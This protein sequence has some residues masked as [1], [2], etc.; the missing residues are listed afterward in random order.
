MIEA[1]RSA[2]SRFVVLATLAGGLPVAAGCGSG[3]DDARSAAAA[4]TSGGGSSASGGLAGAAG[5]SASGG[6]SGAAGA[7]A[8]GGAAGTG[9]GGTSGTAASGGSSGSGFTQVGVCGHRGE[10]SVNADEFSGFEEYFL[11]GEDGLGA[12]ICIVHFD[13]ERAGDPPDG[14]P[15]CLWSHRVVLSNPSV[16]LD[17]NGVC[18]NS[19]LMLGADAIAALDGS[20]AAYGFVNEYAGHVSVL[21]KYD[22][23]LSTWG[24]F[25][26]AT[27]DPDAETLKFERRNGFC[28]Y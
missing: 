12:D 2:T 19:E 11:I 22:D 20:E 13:V 8:S 7:S 9:A 21:M 27:Y 24:P 1:T 25:G 17:E 10:A 15:D 14:C 3:D 4:G 28:N 6:L 5:A 23:D 18:E 16:T 26:N